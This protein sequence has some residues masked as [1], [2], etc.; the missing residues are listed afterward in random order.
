MDE[1]IAETP[2]ATNKAPAMA[3]MAKFFF[4]NTTGGS[5]GLFR[6]AYAIVLL[7]DLVCQS[8]KWEL[9]YSNQGLPVGT[10]IDSWYA[11]SIVNTLYFVWIGVLLLLVIGVQT[12]WT[13][14]FNYALLYYFTNALLDYC[15]TVSLHYGYIVLLYECFIV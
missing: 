2:R 4:S 14:I 6:V 9:L 5:E 10:P 1:K 13:A 15:V 8:S 3:T 12:R 7:L 11:P